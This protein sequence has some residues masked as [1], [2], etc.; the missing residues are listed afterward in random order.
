M[1]FHFTG[2]N[3]AELSRDYLRKVFCNINL[4]KLWAYNCYHFG[5]QLQDQFFFWG[6]FWVLLL[7]LSKGQWFVLNWFSIPDCSS[8]FWKSCY[9]KVLNC[10][11][12]PVHTFFEA[13]NLKNRKQ[14]SR[15]FC[16]LI[17]LLKIRSHWEPP[18]TQLQAWTG[19]DTVLMPSI[20]IYS[21]I[22][23]ESFR[24]H[25]IA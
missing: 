2:V 14:H 22:L 19:A 17:L 5:C 7:D 3:P 23:L 24:I 16:L 11:P 10:F 21:L 9:F 25:N 4:L 15:F 20:F 18:N 12:I 1:F 8:W 13:K 6:L